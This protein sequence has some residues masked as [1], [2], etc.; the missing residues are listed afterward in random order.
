MNKEFIKSLKQISQKT[1]KEGI[2]VTMLQ[3]ETDIPLHR[4]D[5]TAT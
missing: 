1:I 2:P 3:T 5:F 4:Y